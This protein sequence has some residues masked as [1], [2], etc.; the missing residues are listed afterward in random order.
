MR[1]AAAAWFAGKGA[2]T[3]AG[4]PYCL[5][6]HDMWRGNIILPEVAEY[7]AA[8]HARRDG[9]NGFP[10]HQWVHH[11]LSSQAMVFNLVGPLIVRGDLAPLQVA[12]ER[13]GIAWPAGTAR[14]G[15]EHSD[16]AMFNEDPAHPTSIDVVVEGEG[17]NLYIE[18]KMVERGFGGCSVFADGDCEGMNPYP[19]RPEACYLHHIGRKY[20]TMMSDMGFG[21]AAAGP[22]SEPATESAT[23]TVIAPAPVS[24]LTTGPVCPF[25]SYYQFYREVM[26][27]I[28]S[29]GRFVLLHDARN[30]AFLKSV[31]GHPPRGLWPFLVESIPQHLRSRVGRVTMQ[32]VVDA[33]DESGRHADWV[34]EFR[35]KYGV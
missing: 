24:N 26:F 25:A 9:D 17:G 13:A 31:D 18:S 2:E 27:A 32:S 14:A 3:A 8:E 12:M 7:V 16:C 34:G 4:R 10:L 30:P 20:W 11:G 15:F 29:G 33:I 21:Q 35:A 19:D 28:A 22:G 1:R 23:A 6:R 5:A